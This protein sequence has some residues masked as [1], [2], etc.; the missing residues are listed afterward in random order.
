VTAS[1]YKYCTTVLPTNNDVVGSRG[2]RGWS[3]VYSFFLNSRFIS[4]LPY[5]YRKHS[6]TNLV[7]WDYSKSIVNHLSTVYPSRH[8]HFESGS[9]EC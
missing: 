5:Q 9:V 8:G 3:L 1:L 2:P 4:Y 7:Y 6:G